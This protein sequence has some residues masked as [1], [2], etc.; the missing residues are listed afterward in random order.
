MRLL[1]AE[2]KSVGAV[3]HDFDLAQS[4]LRQFERARADRTVVAGLTSVQRD[5]LAKI[6]EETREL[7]M[8]RNILETPAAFFTN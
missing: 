1:L 4:G 8:E 6:R 7:R 2:A 5:G 3:A